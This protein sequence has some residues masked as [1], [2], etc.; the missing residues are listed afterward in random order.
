MLLF[1]GERHAWIDQESCNLI[2]NKLYISKDPELIGS[3][4]AFEKMKVM[5]LTAQEE[6]HH[7]KS[8]NT[9]LDPSLCSWGFIT[10]KFKLCFWVKCNMFSTFQT[11]W[12][13][14]KCPWQFLQHHYCIHSKQIIK[15][16]SFITGCPLN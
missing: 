6:I 13:P 10:L 15:M 2:Q 11:H 1:K 7:F 3:P 4:R 14:L 9:T 8:I 12:L 16:N 5:F